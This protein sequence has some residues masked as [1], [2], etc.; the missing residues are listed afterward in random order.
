[1]RS[2]LQGQVQWKG[3]VKLG[4]FCKEIICSTSRLRKYGKSLMLETRLG[5]AI[6]TICFVT[7]K[8]SC[9]KKVQLP[10][11]LVFVEPREG[12]H[13]PRQGREQA[14]GLLHMRLRLPVPGLPARIST[15]FFPRH[16][17]PAELQNLS[18]SMFNPLGPNDPNLVDLGGFLEIIENQ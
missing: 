8:S 16:T 3:F 11:C 1:M 13:L 17:R 15:Q 10:H 9:Y 2:C 18:A 14:F 7:L 6:Y 12:Q 5:L 4:W